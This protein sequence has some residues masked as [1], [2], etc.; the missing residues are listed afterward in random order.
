MEQAIHSFRFQP[1]IVTSAVS[2]ARSDGL[3]H[4]FPLEP[5][6]KSIQKFYQHYISYFV[7]FK[8]VVAYFLPLECKIQENR[9]CC[10]SYS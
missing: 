9:D 8:K 1:R 6:L 7:A 10:L 2:K 3:I 4:S 5:N